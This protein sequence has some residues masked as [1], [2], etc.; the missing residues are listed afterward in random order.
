MIP[1]AAS[2]CREMLLARGYEVAGE[3]GFPLHGYRGEEEI[4]V[5]YV[6]QARVAYVRGVPGGTVCVLVT[7]TP[8]AGKAKLEMPPTLENFT[9]TELQFNPANFSPPHTLIPANEWQGKGGKHLLPRIRVTDRMARH[10]G[11]RTGDVIRVE[12]PH[13]TAG[14]EIIHKV[15]I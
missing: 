8:I 14:V 1:K 2:V 3:G 10:L 4:E 13:D 9:V 5:Q 12:T 11:A 15:V 7:E 6:P